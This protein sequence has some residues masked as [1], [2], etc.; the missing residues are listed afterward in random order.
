MEDHDGTKGNKIPDTMSKKLKEF[1][2]QR[3][4]LLFKRPAQVRLPV[5]NLQQI[6]SAAARAKARKQWIAYRVL[7]FKVVQ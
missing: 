7:R 5:P 3:A 4:V 1:E 2:Y 6:D